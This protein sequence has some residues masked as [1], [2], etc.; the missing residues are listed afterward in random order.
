MAWK[1]VILSTTADQ[2]IFTQN[3]SA[4]KNSIVRLAFTT[5]DREPTNTAGIF[6]LSGPN[7][8]N[9]R[10]KQGS[11]LWYEEQGGG[12]FTYTTYDIEPLR[13]YNIEP[14][15]KDIVSNNDVLTIPEG[16]YFVIQNKSD[17]N[18]FF[19]IVGEGTFTLT[20]WQMLSFTF[21]RETQIRIK[22]TG[23]DISYFYGEAPS[24]TQLSKATKDMLEEVKASVDLLNANAATRAEV[25]E[26]G[27]KIYYDRYSPDVSTTINTIDP[28]VILEVPMPL[29]ETD[30]DFDSEVLK[31]GEMLD[32]ILGIKYKNENGT[33]TESA[34]NFS[35]KISKTANTIPITDLDIYDT[36]LGM[37]LDEIKLD[38][39]EDNGTL[40][41]TVYFNNWIHTDTNKYVNIK[42]LF[43][44]PLTVTLRIKSEQAVWKE[45]TKTF[46]TKHINKLI[47]TNA[48]F[49]K[50]VHFSTTTSY[51]SLFDNI[52]G[53]SYNEVANT[54]YK[55][56]DNI[57]VEKL[58][59]GTNTVYNVH[60]PANKIQV[61]Y[62]TGSSPAVEVYMDG[63]TIPDGQ[64]LTSIVI[65]NLTNTDAS[66]NLNMDFLEKNKSDRAINKVANPNVWNV[67][68]YEPL[69]GQSPYTHLFERLKST[70]DLGIIKIITR[71]GD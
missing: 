5:E 19:S 21:T 62:Y 20:K 16:A 12:I 29:L 13:N 4:I 61:K 60:D 40:K 70:M 8:W 59:S 37:I 15:H 30:E 11:Y 36:V 39:N 35:A 49:N 66:I 51:N 7:T 55:V 24:L 58:A 65:E 43:K 42:D 31:D 47:H 32:F 46:A 56:K 2:I 69:L 50:R 23:K 17:D 63:F 34:I 68:L 53:V 57:V 52:N 64:K 9:G 6:V 28:T 54:V 71:K 1:K 26:L 41:A 38:W 10:V 67:S 14:V 44:A 27:K 22:G 48:R 33:D 18:I 25:R 3:T 45:S